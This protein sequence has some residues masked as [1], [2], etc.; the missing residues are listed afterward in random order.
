MHSSNSNNE[1]KPNSNRRLWLLLLSR[2]SIALGVI[3][4]VGIAS[5]F[6]W[7]WRFIHEDL[8]PLVERNL[9]QLLGRPV[10]LGQV[11]GFSF[12]SLQFGSL[13]IPAT[14]T[15]PDRLA[16]QAVEV[17]FSPWEL[18]LN[19][20][21][22]LD[23]TLVQPDVYIEQAKDGRW[24]TTEIKTQEGAGFI[25]TDLETIR[26]Q[27]AD[28][29]LVPTE[30]PGRPKGP[31]VLDRVSGIARFLD[32]NQRIRYELSGQP[33][34]GGNFKI[35]GETRP[36]VEQTNLTLQG[37]NL[38]AAD[39]SRL[40]ELP[41][42]LQAG[43]VDGNLTVQFPRDREQPAITGTASVSNVAAQIENIPQKFTNTNGRLQ[44]QGYEIAFD[45]LDTRYGK[46]PV[47]VSGAIDTQKG[48]NLSGQVKAVSVNNLVDTLNVDVPVPTT[49]EVRANIQVT[50]SLRQPTLSGTVSTI[51]QAQI[52]RIK[53]SNISSR[54]R[55]TA[56][57]AASEITFS[58]IRATPTVGGQ[59]AGS[60]Q[61]KLAPQ[62]RVTFDFQAEDVPGDALARAYG[63]SPPIAIGDIS[64]NAQV[65]GSVGNLRTVVQLQAPAA[66]YPGTAQVVVTDSGNISIQ[67][68][69]FNVAGGTV[70]ARGRV[71]EG[72]WQFF[73]DADQIQL[74]RFP[75]VPP[76]FQGRLSG[77]FNLSGTTASFQPSAIQA[78][79]QARLSGV[80]GGTVNLRD[81]SLN[82]GRWQASAYV[83]Q[84]QL[85]QFSQELRGRLS[86]DVRT[87]GTTDSFQLSDIQAQ[88]Q[89]RFSQGLALIE[90]PLTAQFRWNGE[91][92]QVQKATAPGLSAE[93]T[94]AVQAEGT[95]APQIT[96]INLD[97]Q[98]E[99]YNLQ[100]LPFNLPGSVE[101][102]GRADF[103]GQVTGT[104]TAP[105]AVGDIRLQN[106]TVNGLAFDP[107]LTG[108]L[109]FQAG[110]GTEL[111]AT[112]TQDRIAFTLGPNNL[113]TS[114][115]VRRDQVV[116]TGKS[117]G[118][119]LLVNVQGFPV[120]VLKD[121]IP[122]ATV[123]L[124]PVA[125]EISGDLEIN[126]AEST[127]IG[128]VAIAEPRIGRIGADEFRGRFS[129]DNGAATLT[130]GELRL[131]ESRIFLSGDLQAGRDRQ[132][133]FQINFDQARIENILQALAF[134]NF[135][136]ISGGLQP[137]DFARSEAV[138]PVPVGLPDASL[139]TQLRRFS[140]IEA[141]LQQQGLQRDASPVPELAELDGTIS[142]N[143]AVTGSLQSGLNASFNLLGQDWEWGDYT[144]DEVVAQGNFEDGVLTLL[145]LRIDLGD[146]LLAFT[147]QLGQEQLS[148]QVRVEELPVE[149][150]EP[151]LP[152]S[153]VEVTGNLNALVT[154]AGSLENPRAIGELTLVEGTLNAQPVQTAQLS[155]SYNNARLNFGS[156]VLV[157]GT[158]PIEITG[159]IPIGLPFAS[160]QPNSNQISLQANVQDEG[161]ALLNLF[162]NQVTWVEGQGQLNVEVQGT[163]NQPIVT[164]NLSVFDATLKAQALP[165]PLTD[166]TGT[167][168]FNGDRIVV[169][170]IQGE[171]NQGEVTASGVLPIFA[172]REAQQLAATNPLTV[173]LDNLAVNL[174]GLYQGGVRG[175]VVITGTALA[176]EIG[177]E[178]R[179]MNGQVSLGQSADAGSSAASRGASG[180]TTTVSSPIEF[181]GLRL[182]LD[183]D[184]RVTR[185]PILSFEAKG[186]ITINGT[187]ANPRPQG[188]VRLT[189]GQ[190]N[191]FTTQFTLD[192][193][194][195]QT[196]TF[197][198]KQGLNPILDI[199]LAA[200]VPEVTRTSTRTS[201]V[202]SEISDIPATS[203]GGFRTVG[204]EARVRGPA[205]ELAEN[206]ELTSEPGRSESEIIAL[207]GGS[208]V[209]TL[210]R[211]DPLL[212]LANIAGSALLSPFVEDF[213]A[214]GE[215]I[216]F[217]ELRLY[218]TIVTDP[219]SEISVLGLATE[220]VVD[221][222]DDL[223][224]ALSRVFAADEPFRYNIIYRLND[225][226]LVR[227]STNFAG[228]SR[229]LLEYESRF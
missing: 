71:A 145:P 114:F 165:Q 210:G 34:R 227:A 31:V 183:E 102:A 7:G 4:L 182:I 63:A 220:A 1:P 167:A 45:N 214:I 158:E 211:G 85:N 175:N 168:Q 152:E 12:N 64:A 109:N 21:L 42:T 50:G 119:T 131:G 38:L 155:L 58:D 66:T 143:I 150:V 108:N 46:I 30:R 113:P 202:S 172:N 77:E 9:K 5:G 194:Y 115:F 96:G 130:E 88:G 148:G 44:F 60:G 100:D 73:V 94:V 6:W 159:S 13:S 198:P 56:S 147:G 171:Y 161:L 218:P 125:G 80:A 139:L 28:V 117:Q 29:V 61:I 156:T 184:V 199:R 93:G 124:G 49:G 226:F 79:G 99:D 213:T 59:I 43:R 176:P 160:V 208:F 47:Q 8:A 25:Q 146:G 224:V 76:Q 129:Y 53:F 57:E 90:Q 33:T 111:Q 221:I 205:S 15:D 51:K 128:E 229:A 223:S 178:I 103:T 157:A 217:S 36:A 181:A 166:V 169:E 140:E 153:P 203:F 187:L 67:D 200:S 192:R 3:L 144:I 132:F 11:E 163:L 107:V 189:G 17:E 106:L 104:P 120:A 26:V 222:T 105:S 16:A 188:V 149:V 32:Q 55:L 162:T 72:R 201:A 97:V 24:V 112:G 179:L 197:T 101:L 180:A 126:L 39:I 195:E 185:Q 204:V 54:F 23:V 177:G 65:S 121:L 110:Q 193:G 75:Q 215:A 225:Q 87:A 190:V 82:A 219:E 170:G 196:A 20:T 35:T 173:S 138:Q 133:Q 142:G 84:L 86:G 151:F 81:I 136:D 92:L 216:G 186:D 62:S 70:N 19:R 69:V 134:Y 41:I 228:E 191:L 116:A 127:A 78:T 135:Q 212:G 52:D 122:G 89:V 2:T 164:G 95:E 206:L 10:E 174:Q 98:A 154:L 83:S 22:Q 207:L 123:D 209:N 137:P 141:L 48:Y 74:S 14:P 118:E 68:G 18:L 91:L 27:N 37:Q 40:V